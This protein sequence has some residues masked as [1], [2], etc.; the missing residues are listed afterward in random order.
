[1][2]EKILINMGRIMTLTIAGLR[3]TFLLRNI[4]KRVIGMSTW[5]PTI[6]SANHTDSRATRLDGG[7]G[8]VPLDINGWMP[9]M[10]PWVEFESETSEKKAGLI[11]RPV[12]N[13]SESKRTEA[14]ETEGWE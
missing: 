9:V 13:E 1:M 7:W 4:V 14:D 2:H 10:F 12:V 8:T 5:P 6:I 11:E 3:R